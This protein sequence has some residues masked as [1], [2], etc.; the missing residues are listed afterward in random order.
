MDIHELAQYAK[1]PKELEAHLL[2]PDHEF[3]FKCRRCGKCC[4][5]QDTILFTARDIFNIAKELGKTPAQVV[6]ECAEVYIGQNS[7]IPVV[8][9]VTKGLQRRCP[10]L[11]ED[12]RCSVHDCKPTVCALF[13]VG[14][15]AVFDRVEDGLL[16]KENIHVKYIINDITCGSAKRVN[17]IRDWLARFGIS[18]EDEFFLLWSTVT[19]NLGII[20][21]KLEEHKCSQNLM[22]MIWNGILHTL[23]LDYD[24]EQEFFPQFEAAADKLTKICEDI[25]QLDQFTKGKGVLPQNMLDILAKKS[26]GLAAVPLPSAGIPDTQMGR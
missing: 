3:R 10:L 1:G 8:H 14:R 2:T 25:Y 22:V 12:G 19:S 20:V 17:T 26:D 9:M 4:K 11:Q 13:P 18:E 21:R 5:H 16:K 23:Y 24:T 7:R 15:V 6:C